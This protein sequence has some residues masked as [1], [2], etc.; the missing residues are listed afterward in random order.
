MT[1]SGVFDPASDGCA[2][3][4][5]MVGTQWSPGPFSFSWASSPPS[6]L[7]HPH[8]SCL[9]HGGPALPHL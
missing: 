3:S 5:P 6:S 1:R 4:S 8:L 9:R 2:S 7:L